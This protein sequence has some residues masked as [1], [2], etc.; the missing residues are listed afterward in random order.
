MSEETQR[1]K[2]FMA[3]NEFLI[4]SQINFSETSMDI[5][6]F[7]SKFIGLQGNITSVNSWSSDDRLN[8][9]V[10]LK[11]LKQYK[12]LKKKYASN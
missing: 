9:F 11:A 4:V 8:D 10:N 5:D 6:A 12:R 7:L 3:E 1:A 2:S